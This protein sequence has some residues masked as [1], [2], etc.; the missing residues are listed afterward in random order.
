MDLTLM[1]VNI[2]ASFD[3][4]ARKIFAVNI[5]VD[6]GITLREFVF[7]GRQSSNIVYEATH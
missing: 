3:T 1:N 6:V 5:D 2:N 4:S 7:Y